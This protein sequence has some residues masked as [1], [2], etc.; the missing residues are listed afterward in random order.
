MD[1]DNQELDI[2]AAAAGI[3]GSLFG[4]GE[5]E[6]AAPE[7]EVELPETVEGGEADPAPVDP[8]VVDPKPPA[9]RNAPGSWAK[10]QHDRWSKID[11]ATQDYIELREKQM[12]Q[13]VEQIKGDA[14]YG[15]SIRDI[16]TPY[17][18][19]LASQGVDGPKAVQVLLNTHYKL[20]NSSPAEKQAV[21]ADIAK[22]YGIEIPSAVPGEPSSVDPRVKALE[23]N[24]ASLKSAMTAREQEALQASRTR[25]ATEV[26]AFA[27]DPAHPYFDE[28]SGDMIPLINAGMSL[29]DAYERAVWGNPVTRAK[30]IA[31]SQTETEAKLREKAKT[32]AAAARKASGGNVRSRDTSRAPTEPMG[33][34]EDTMKSTLA[35]I[36]TRTH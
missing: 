14:N 20:S 35:G 3:A 24:F 29:P 32:E 12:S 13:G 21:L 6:P 22:H 18:A 30:E 5:T 26:N 34:M 23:E 27:S 36:R 4:P 28:V 1:T 8:A 2:D 16:I 25:T 7:A 9:A 11:P 15:R 17:N 19:L 10:E 33:T 31:K